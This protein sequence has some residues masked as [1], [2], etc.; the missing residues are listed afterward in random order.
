MPPGVKLLEHH[1]TISDRRFVV[2]PASMTSIASIPQFG[3]SRLIRSE[4]EARKFG[5]TIETKRTRARQ[6]AT[7]VQ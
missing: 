1:A 4:D 2:R 3:G 6:A 5:G 7:D